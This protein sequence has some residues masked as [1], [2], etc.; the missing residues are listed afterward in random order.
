[1]HKQATSSAAIVGQWCDDFSFDE[2]IF[3]G[4]AIYLLNST[5][6]SKLSSDTNQSDAPAPAFVL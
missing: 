5:N 2:N 6:P 1:M 4:H 3:C